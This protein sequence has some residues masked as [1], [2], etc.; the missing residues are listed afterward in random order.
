[1]NK[2]LILSLI[3][4]T[5]FT[6]TAFGADLD[7]VSGGSRSSGMKIKSSGV[8]TFDFSPN[9]KIPKLNVGEEK[10]LKENV[11][12]FQAPAVPQNKFTGVQKNQD[13]TLV[14]FDSK[15]SQPETVKPAQVFVSA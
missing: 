3:S 2:I 4:V 14:S 8:P 9:G 12:D 10:T 7:V 6:A 13:P 15:K 11:K 5:V 1:M